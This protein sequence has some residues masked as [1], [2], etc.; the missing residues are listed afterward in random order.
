MADRIV[1]LRAGRVEQVGTPLDLYNRPANAFVAG[2]I[3]TPRM[4]FLK[5]RV[6]ATDGGRAVALDGTGGIIRPEAAL[7][8]LSV[9]TPVTIGIRPEHVALGHKG[10]NDV[11]FAVGHSEQLGGATTLFFPEPGFA[12]QL[13]GQVAARRG[14]GMAL[15][16]PPER[17]HVFDS[18]DKALPLHQMPP[19]PSAITQPAA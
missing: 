1:V 13:P 3:G 6:A 4:N 12:V 11:S 10:L 7:R 2:F 17:V 5:G 19:V 8:D 15:N 9:G 16:L 18:D 14:E